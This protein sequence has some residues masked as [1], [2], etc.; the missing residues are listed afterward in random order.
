[1][2]LPS[3]ELDVLLLLIGWGRASCKA[4]DITPT[5]PN[6][7]RLLDQYDLLRRV[8]FLRMSSEEFALVKQRGE[9]FF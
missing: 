3:R 4:L 2:P 5:G 1:M 7:R 8:R 9:F 6:I